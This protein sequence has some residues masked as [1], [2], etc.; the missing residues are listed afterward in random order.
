MFGL[1]L[2]GFIGISLF[3]LNEIVVGSY[4]EMT[5][6]CGM[7]TPLLVAL[8][9]VFLRSGGAAYCSLVP[10]GGGPRLR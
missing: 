6:L 4:C 10:K 8:V 5:Y 2:V 7:K 9:E 1:N 3:F